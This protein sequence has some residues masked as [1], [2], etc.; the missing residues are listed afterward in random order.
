MMKNRTY[1]PFLIES[2]GA[3]MAILFVLIPAPAARILNIQNT[4]I[5]AGGIISAFAIA[6]LSSKIF[7]LREERADRQHEINI[8]SEKLTLFRRL[9]Y[10]VMTSDKFRS[11]EKESDLF[12]AME[13]ICGSSNWQTV[14]AARFDYS[15]S[16]IP[17]YYAPC[18]K[19][20]QYNEH[21]NDTGISIQHKN[22][23][24]DILTRIDVKYKSKEFNGSILSEI[25]SEFHS[26]YLPMLE[27]LT[28]QNTGIPDSLTKI[29]QSLFIIMISGV[30]LPIILQSITVNDNLN[31]YLT[32]LFVWVTS[33]SLIIFLIN[34]YNFLM[35]DV[36]M[37]KTR[38]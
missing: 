28:L 5:T 14:T 25:A 34:F 11:E 32:L 15:L 26:H 12:A 1:F 30:L 24:S 33:M 27:R 18:N 19:I 21:F 35:E 16:E 7:A 2:I 9:L 31:I 8:L 20:A 37:V 3:L 22:E 23:V 29:F 4:L 17:E 10:Y 6:Y 38:G 13:K 36:H